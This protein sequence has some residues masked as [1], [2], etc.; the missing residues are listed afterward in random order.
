MKHPL[1]LF[2]NQREHRDTFC[3]ALRLEALPEV[4]SPAL[5]AS[6]PHKAPGSVQDSG[7]APCYTNT[8]AQEAPLAPEECSDTGHTPCKTLENGFKSQAQQG[9]YTHSYVTSQTEL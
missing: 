2:T 3:Y 6:S 5:A 4:R 8:K 9:Q 1:H 7:H